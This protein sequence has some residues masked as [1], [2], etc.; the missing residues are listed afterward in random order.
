MTIGRGSW[1]DYRRTILESKQFADF[2]PTSWTQ[3]FGDVGGWRLLLRALYW[4]FHE[5]H[6]WWQAQYLVKLECHFSWQA[7]HAEKFWEKAGARNVALF[8]TKCVAK[9]GGVSSSK[10]R[11]RDDDFI[12]G[13]WSD[14]RRIMLEWSHH[15]HGA[16]PPR[17]GWRL[18][19]PKNGLGIALVRRLADILSAF[20]F[21]WFWFFFMLSTWN[22]HPRLARELLVHYSCFM[23]TYPSGL[24]ENVCCVCVCVCLHLP[25]CFFFAPLLRRIHCD[26]PPNWNH[27]VPSG[28]RSSLL[29]RTG[30]PHTRPSFVAQAGSKDILNAP[31]VEAFSAFAPAD[32][33]DPLKGNDAQ[34]QRIQKMPWQFQAPHV[35]SSTCCCESGQ[36]GIQVS[37]TALTCVRHTCVKHRFNRTRRP[38]LANTRFMWKQVAWPCGFDKSNLCPPSCPPVA[39]VTKPQ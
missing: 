23:F 28:T 3:I 9:M 10:R 22:F 31:E 8:H 33:G 32:T 14:Y 5:S 4:T 19:Q 16:S 25:L 34:A 13:P 2:S 1:A 20:F 30:Q 26:V 27:R 15:H 24:C 37:S 38:G 11:V 21:L 6:F 36:L 35:E 12:L 7:Q 18:V 17:N 39:S 29:L